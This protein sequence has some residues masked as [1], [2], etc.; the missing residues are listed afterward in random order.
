MAL[1]PDDLLAALPAAPE[2]DDVRVFVDGLH[3]SFT[4]E[5]CAAQ[6]EAV[7]HALQRLRH[8]WRE[9]PE[10][11][12]APIVARLQELTAR[13]EAAVARS[14][15]PEGA[16]TPEE[17]LSEVFGYPAFRPGQREIIDAVLAGRD[18]VGVMPTGAG[19]S[20]TFQIP[21]RILG[22]TTLVVSPLIALMKDQVDALREV[23]VRAACLNSSLDAE[24]RSRVVGELK[25]GEI[26]VLYAAPEGLQASVAWA[27]GDVD[28][29]LIAVDEAHCISEWGH[30]WRPAYRELHGLKHRFPQVPVLGLTA[31]ATQRVTDD[32]VQQLAMRRPVIYRGS[33]FRPNLHIHAYKKGSRTDVDRKTPPVRRAI[34]RLVRA[35]QGVSG[36]VYCLSRRST[37]STAKFL[38]E[39][40]I[41]AAAYHAGMSAKERTHAQDA[42][43]DDDVDVVV[44]TIAFGMGIDKSNVRY[45]IHRDMPRSIEGYY[46]EIGRAGRDGLD[47]DCVL[48]YSWAEVVA[49]DRFAEEASDEAGERLRAQARAMFSFAEGFDC[50]HRG[51]AAH[52]GEAMDACG[53]S[54]DVCASFDVLAAAPA[55]KEKARR[56][57]PDDLFDQLRA[58]RLEIAREHHVPAYVVFTDAAL[59]EMARRRP[60][61]DDE[62]RAVPGVGPK[63]FARYGEAFLDLLRNESA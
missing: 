19:K 12:D 36:I 62:L 22:G 51:L 40:G 3:T 50:R 32:I 6:R 23:G 31:T 55:R 34:L 20:M 39:N 8:L 14:R 21:A 43:R 53:S 18:C 35:R 61:T 1:A 56:Y 10:A 24:E 29:S 44:A 2:A 30:D 45:V 49:Y 13:V 57:V 42:F 59:L 60:Q 58:L 37:E 47:A 7:A 5:A 52:F 11:F 48:F 25:R 26:E 9:V 33:F 17:V 28:L 27:L 63:R 15:L 16:P 46:Q 4:D 54:C 41:S 38:R